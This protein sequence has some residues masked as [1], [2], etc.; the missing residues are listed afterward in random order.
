[1]TFVRS[2]ALASFVAL[3]FASVACG[4]SDQASSEADSKV[5]LTGSIGGGGVSTKGFAGISTS[6]GLH[7]TAHEVHKRGERGRNVEVAVGSGG[8]FS[9]DLAR[10]SRWLVTV[11]DAQGGSA[12]VS[13]GGKNVIA[14]ASDGE[15]ARVDVGSLHVV[16]GQAQCDVTIDGRF[17]LQATLAE[18]DDVIV[19]ANGVILEARA[20]AA[21]AQAA[22]AEAQKSALDA[23]NAARN[24]ADEARTAAGMVP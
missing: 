12:I 8:Y 16:G 7:V 3:S 17:G 23:A 10:G 14:T 24:A 22:A 4:G 5:T 15:G 21:E 20:A 11:D 2:L 19:A 1:M 13:F 9:V 18:V 6:A